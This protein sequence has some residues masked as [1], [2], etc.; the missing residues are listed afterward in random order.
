[1]SRRPA[2]DPRTDMPTST[3]IDHALQIVSRE[4]I[5]P[6]LNYLEA[7]GVARQTALRVLASPIHK[8]SA[9]RRRNA[10]AHGT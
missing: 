5:G 9:E 8:R 7:A 6:A 10:S 4:G 1:M 3:L 2:A